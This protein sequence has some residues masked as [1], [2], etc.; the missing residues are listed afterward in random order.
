MCSS[1]LSLGGQTPLKLS[2]QIPSEL[3]AGTSARSIDIAEDREKWNDL[4]NQLSIPQ[5]PGGTAVTFEEAKLIASR[6]GFPVLVRPSYVLGGRAMQ[7]VHDVAHLETAMDELTRFG[8]LGREGGLSAERP[9]LIDRFLAGAT[10][11]GRAH[12]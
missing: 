2:G 11:I 12:V 6:V 10:E 3:V 8:S 7:I 5:P 9:V 1:D 4:C